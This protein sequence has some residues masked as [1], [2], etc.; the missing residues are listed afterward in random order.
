M[1]EG[2]DRH[3]VAGV[4]GAGQADAADVVAAQVDQHHVLGPLLLTGEQGL[5]P[6]P[7]HRR[8]PAARGGAGDGTHDDPVALGAEEH[9]G[10]GADQRG[11]VAGD[12][13][14]V[15]GGVARAQPAVDVRG[16]Q[17]RVDLDAVT[18]LDLVDVAD[19]DVAQAAFDVAQEGGLVRAVA[20][21]QRG[22]GPGG[23]AGR[24]GHAGR[25]P[26]DDPGEVGA[27][28]GA[29]V[30]AEGLAP[31]RQPDGGAGVQVVP[32]GVLEQGQDQVGGLVAGA[33]AGG[34]LL[35][36]PGGAVADGGEEAEGVLGAGAVDVEGRLHG[37]QYVPDLA[38]PLEQ[39]VSAGS[40]DQ[41][42]PV[43][44]RGQLGQDGGH[45]DGGDP[46]RVDPQL[47]EPAEADDGRVPV[48]LGALQG[49]QEEHVLPEP[50]A[51]RL[52]ELHGRVR[53]EGALLD[54]DGEGAPA[55]V[56]RRPS[57][58]VEQCGHR[59]T[60]LGWL[61]AVVG[62]AVGDCG[63]REASAVAAHLVEEV[64]DDGQPALRVEGVVDVPAD[65]EVEH[66]EAEGEKKTGLSS[67]TGSFPESTS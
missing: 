42:E 1:R 36:V 47:G 12:E 34:E 8:V 5:D 40:F 19:A 16:G 31:G 35:H 28:G 23:P 55:V 50:G 25:Q 7:V 11:A 59:F 30:G 2:L 17:R 45:A 4:Q 61:G 32:D 10:A 24:L 39:P 53:V 26:F 37:P 3:D 56:G 49:L 66:A 38:G 48:E 21:C 60:F 14:H 46:P 9:L 15:R 58:G 44:D 18:D 65:R 41:P 54:P 62:A 33:V 27:G 13:V 52:V 67:G 63:E 64:L 22:G 57:G 20:D 6:G 29:A 51:Q 43:G